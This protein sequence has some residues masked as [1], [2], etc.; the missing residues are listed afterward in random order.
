MSKYCTSSSQPRVSTVHP[1]ESVDVPSITYSL[2]PPPLILQLADCLST[3]QES[4]ILSMH[5]PGQQQ[6][7]PLPA[8]PCLPDRIIYHRR[9]RR[10]V[11]HS[12]GISR[13]SLF[14]LPFAK[15]GRESSTSSPDPPNWK[16]AQCLLC[17]ANCGQFGQLLWLI[18]GRSVGAGSG[19]GFGHPLESERG[20]EIEL[21]KCSW[22][23]WGI[24]QVHKQSV[25]G[26]KLVSRW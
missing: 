23:T 25:H 13:V 6:S 2:L 10:P 11:L 4:T 12:L 14:F 17:V 8:L 5:V 9:R 7:K 22:H 26:F 18:V 24:L 3:N 20:R 19:F 1:V 15:A 16:Q 21:E